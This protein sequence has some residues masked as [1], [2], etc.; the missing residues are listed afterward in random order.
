MLRRF[1]KKPVGDVDHRGAVEQ[2]GRPAAGA[3]SAGALTE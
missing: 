2:S 3:G 1:P